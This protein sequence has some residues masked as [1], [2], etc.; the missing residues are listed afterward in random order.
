M[1]EII[2]NRLLIHNGLNKLEEKDVTWPRTC[3]CV[4]DCLVCLKDVV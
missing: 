3:K 2:G 4:E 1:A